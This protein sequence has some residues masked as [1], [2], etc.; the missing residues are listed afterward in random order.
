MDGLVIKDLNNAIREQE[1]DEA[2][3]SIAYLRQQIEQTPL[4]ELRKLFFN[5]IQSQTETMMLANVREEYVFKTIDPATI[6][7]FKSEPKRALICILGTFLGG[8]LA[9]IYVLGHH[10][11]RTLNS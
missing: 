5:L 8:F 4:T 9:L 3:S 2:E 10:Y 6:P 7:E 11:I 1:I